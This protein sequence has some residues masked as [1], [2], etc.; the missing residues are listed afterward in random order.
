MKFA[1]LRVAAARWQIESIG[2]EEGYVVFKYTNRPKIE[3]L[4]RAT[5]GRL[6]IV[7]DGSAYWPLDKPFSSGRGKDE[8][9]GL[10]AFTVKTT[11][12]SKK[13]GPLTPAPSPGERELDADALLAIVESVLQSG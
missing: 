6:R 4:K 11:A 5:R 9:A 1:E 7:D 12:N 2:R 3:E 13:E 8:G 10:P